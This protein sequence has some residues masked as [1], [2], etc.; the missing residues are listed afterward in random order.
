MKNHLLIIFLLCGTALCAQQSSD[1]VKET[2]LS[3]VVI[4]AFEQNRQLK[5]IP[6]AVNYYNSSTFSRFSPSSVVQ[7]I[8]SMPGVRLEE[9]SP[10]SYRFNIR[11]SSLR[12]PFGVRN[13]KIYFNDLPF[14]DPSGNTYF[15]QF[16]YYNFNTLEIIKGPGS[17]LYGAGTG[18]VL[19]IKSDDGKDSPEAKIDYSGGSYGY[20]NIAGE[21]RSGSEHFVSTLNYQHEQSSGYRYHSALRRDVATWTGTV[22]LPN[23]GQLK[24][25]WLYSDLFYETPG[26]LTKAEYDANPRLA[27]PTVGSNPGSEKVNAAIFQKTILGGVSYLQPISLKWNNKTVVYG[28]FSELRN[29]GIRNYGRNSEPHTGART[30][31]NFQDQLNQSIINFTAG[32]EIQKGF[33]T[34]N[35]YKN[36]AGYM[37]SLQ[38]SDDIKNRQVFVF[39]QASLEIKSWIITAGASWNWLKI[40]Y[41][42]FA[43][44][45]LP[46]QNVNFDNQIAPR[47]AVLKKF[48]NFSL[49]TS[50]AK[51]FSP[52]SVAEMFPTGSAP[53]ASLNAEKGI[54]YDLGW[55]GTFF[56]KLFID[57]N[58]FY[59]KLD[60]AIVTRKDSLGGDYYINSG[61]TKQQGIEA[62]MNY[63]LFQSSHLLKRSLLYVSYAYH[64]FHYDQFKQSATDFSG[65][66]LPGDPLHNI[67]AGYDLE[68]TNGLYADITYYY[69]GKIPLNDANTVYADSYQLLGSKLGYE[70]SIKHLNM[71]FYV[72]GNNLLNSKYSLGNDL[73]AAGGR[74]FN[75]AAGINYYAGFS[76]RRNR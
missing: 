38:T 60:N 37:D 62:Y 53:N 73:N 32:S 16:G 45:A 27:R 67:S 30:T 41:Q 70:K 24:F 31:F 9:R 3:E 55:R 34:E 4:R 10:G 59:Y 19:L 22:H 43:I 49:Y 2:Q 7:A 51:G 52:P 64:D 58:A 39:G 44:N 14:T 61:K 1:S 6:A 69:A 57:V 76:I 8:N 66:Q 15:N 12:S 25:T 56:R 74:Y 42:R 28:A 65:K 36:K 33:F 75:A 54:N 48:R 5:E 23:E 20:H 47:F 13:V 50:I 26:G 29:P 40:Q 17:S 72:G 18:G 21:F 46:L 35:V 11:G 63:P 71:N 68:L